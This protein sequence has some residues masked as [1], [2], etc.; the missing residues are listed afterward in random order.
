[1]KIDST[2]APTDSAPAAISRAIKDCPK[3]EH[4]RKE[5]NNREFFNKFKWFHS[6]YHKKISA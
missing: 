3:T 1:M 5:I 4:Q 6:W 2:A